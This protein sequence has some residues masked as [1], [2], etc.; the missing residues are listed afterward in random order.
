[1]SN[2]HLEER[3]LTSAEI[4]RGIIVDLFCDDVLLP[5]GQTAKR[6]Y[7]KHIG[8]SCVV[9]LTK[10]GDVLLVKQYRYPFSA[11][12]PEIPAGKLDSADED[13]LEAAKR[14]LWEET[15]AKCD[16]LIPLG[17]YYPTCAYSTEV[18]HMYLAMDI[19]PGLQHLDEDE[20]VVCETVPIK[21]LVSQ[22]MNG[23]IKDGKTQLAI[24][25]AYYYMTANGI[26]H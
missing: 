19:E 14:E 9:P 12:L 26:I 17:D 1:M 11:V 20:F 8:A 18:I 25:K 16:S 13:P 4:Y 21:S 23:K 15:G 10:E 24:L 2:E 7:I 5:N 3:Q 6:E 22:I